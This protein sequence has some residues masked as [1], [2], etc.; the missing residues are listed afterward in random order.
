M[1][2]TATILSIDARNVKCTV[3][4]EKVCNEMM[5]DGRGNCSKVEWEQEWPKTNRLRFARNCQLGLAISPESVSSLVKL[6]I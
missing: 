6:R 4:A 2:Q 1:P 5:V 3:A